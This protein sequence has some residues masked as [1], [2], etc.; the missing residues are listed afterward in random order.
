ML[1]SY[2]LGLYL[3]CVPGGMA[4]TTLRLVL[5]DVG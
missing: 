4:G 5:V 1:R 3:P 2:V